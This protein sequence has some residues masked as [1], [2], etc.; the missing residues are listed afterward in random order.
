MNANFS[1]VIRSCFVILL[2]I[3]PIMSFCQPRH[4]DCVITN[5]NIVDVKTGKILNNR[6]VAIDSNR[7]SAIYDKK[8]SF[9]AAKIVID[10]K[11]KYL[12]PGLWDMHAHYQWSHADLDPLLIANGITGI[13]DMWRDMPAFVEI[14]PKTERAGIVSPDL[15]QSGD[16]LD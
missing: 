8:I 2:L 4:H 10:G 5:V 11:G 12:I 9:S 1:I 6:A 3:M 13:R 7:I 16:L 14:P 15:Y